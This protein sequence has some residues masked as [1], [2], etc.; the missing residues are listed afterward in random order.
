MKLLFIGGGAGKT[1]RGSVG[2]E[3]GN[4]LASMIGESKLMFR[5]LSLVDLIDEELFTLT[6][7]FSERQSLDAPADVSIACSNGEP[8][9]LVD[10]VTKG[11]GC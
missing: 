5:M 7:C 6:T 8:R 11:L 1:G 2:A 4:M 10:R 9:R 3:G